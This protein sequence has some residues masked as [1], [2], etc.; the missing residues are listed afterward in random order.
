MW[1]YPRPPRLERTAQRVRVVHGGVTVGDS[2]A[3]WRVL[4][5]S[6]APAF[7]LPPVDVDGTRLRNADGRSWCEWK[8][9]ASYFDVVVGQAVAPQAAWSYP[10]PTPAFEVIADH[11]AF[12]CQRV[13]ACFVDDEQVDPNEGDFY[14][15][16]VTSS[17]VGPFK[18]APGSLGW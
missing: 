16:W 8:G 13:D 11:L 10:A 2:T 14:G 4:E 12:Y 15:G 17:V 5:T 3:A 1:D 6:Q 7:Y 18:G 9:A